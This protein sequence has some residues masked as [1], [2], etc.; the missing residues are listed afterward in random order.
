M[1]VEAAS[2]KLHTLL[3]EFQVEHDLTYVE[4][5]G[6]LLERQQTLVKYMLRD[7]RHPD[8]PERKADEE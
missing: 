6:L 7:E 5:A 3:V 1:L 8:D 4:M 2:A